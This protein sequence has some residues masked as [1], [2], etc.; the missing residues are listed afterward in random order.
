MIALEI[1]YSVEYEVHR[2]KET[3]KELSWYK[4]NGYDVL[5]PQGLSETSSED[6]IA[7]AVLNTY[8]EEEYAIYAGMLNSLWENYL[9]KLKNTRAI[10]PFDLRDTYIVVLTQYGTNGSYFPEESKII[11]NRARRDKDTVLGTLMHEIVHISVEHLIKKYAVSHWRKER[12]VDLLCEKYFSDIRKMRD[13]TQEDVS[14]VDIAFTEKYP[15]IE[16]ITQVI[17]SNK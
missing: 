7:A 4:E 13:L 17:G 10:L 16:A 1:K 2:V 5:Y 8:S 6:E 15:D 9:P 3:L 11:I 12:L 14:P